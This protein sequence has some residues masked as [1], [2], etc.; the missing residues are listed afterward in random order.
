ME[1]LMRPTLLAGVASLF[2]LLSLF[3][4]DAGAEFRK[5]VELL[6]FPLSMRDP[7]GGQ[8]PD[9]RATFRL[10]QRAG[11]SWIRIRLENARPETLY[12]VWAVLTPV[13]Q[14]S[15]LLFPG[16]NVG[17]P[18]TGARATPM[19][20]SDVAADLLDLHI[21]NP[22]GVNDPN[23]PNGF[24]TDAAGAGKFEADLDF[25]LL[26]GAYPFQRIVV[27]PQDAAPAPVLDPVAF[28][29]ALTPPPAVF[30]VVSHCTDNMG[31][32]LVPG[33]F[34]NWFRY[35]PAPQD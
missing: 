14:P 26:G 20:S 17:S 2:L 31:H 22:G 4:A 30:V 28:N 27:Q 35:A 16:M 23:P 24:L 7:C 18:L 21:L 10:S 12:S 11:E 1:R 29:F 34:E 3:G 8:F 15:P 32:G 5:P 13:P 25:P 9:A 6:P 19:V 33:A